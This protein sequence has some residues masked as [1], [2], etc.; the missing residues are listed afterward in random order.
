MFLRKQG[1]YKEANSNWILLMNIHMVCFWVLFI[2]YFMIPIE[3]KSPLLIIMGVLMFSF[4]VQVF[5]YMIK[6]ELFKDKNPEGVN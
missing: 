4:A 6:P 3:M 1:K 2:G 5:A